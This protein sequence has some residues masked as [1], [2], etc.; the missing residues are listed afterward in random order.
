MKWQGKGKI[1]Q[2]CESESLFSIHP[3]IIK[4]LLIVCWQMILPRTHRNHSVFVIDDGSVFTCGNNSKGECGHPVQADILVPTKVKEWMYLF[5]CV[6][7][8]VCVSEWERE[9]ERERERECV[10]VCVCV[11]ASAKESAVTRRRLI[12]W[13][14]QRLKNECVCVCVCVCVCLCI[15]TQLEILVP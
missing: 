12:S 7:V 14:P 2:R 4:F 13:C 5:V 15:T 11:R 1:M 10:C 9:R 8:C 3:K 6:C